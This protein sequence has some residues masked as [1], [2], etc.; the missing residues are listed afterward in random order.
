METKHDLMLRISNEGHSFPHWDTCGTCE[1][2]FDEVCK[3]ERERIKELIDKI[4][5]TVHNNLKDKN[6][7][8]PDMVQ[9]N[10]SGM[11]LSLEELKKQI[12]GEK[13]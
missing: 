11:I 9:A 2:D 10:L 12:S 7:K 13:K 4:L 5:L 8:L 1:E 6:L 3:W